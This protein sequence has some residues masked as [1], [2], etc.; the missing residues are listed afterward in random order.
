VN[1]PGEHERFRRLAFARIEPA[2]TGANLVVVA[3]KAAAKG[4]IGAATP[5]RRPAE[6]V[7]LVARRTVPL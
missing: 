2:Q 1:D 7:C 3:R 5:R 6:R 4:P